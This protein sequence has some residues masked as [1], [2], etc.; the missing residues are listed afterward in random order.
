M[1]VHV[2]MRRPRPVDL[3]VRWGAPTRADELRAALADHLGLA[4]P[5][6]EVGG[7]PVPD[8]TPLGV[9]PLVDGV[10]VLVGT[11]GSAPREPTAAGALEVVVVAGPDAGR[12]RPLAPPGLDV[13]RAPG[14]GLAVDDPSLS[15]THAR[16][17]VGPD[18]VVLED[19]GSTNGVLVDGGP[20][21]GRRPVHTGSSIELGATRLAVRRA[22]GAGLPTRPV[23]DGTL[24][25]AAP[26][27]APPI[28]DAVVVEA[29]RA[30]V[31]E[32]RARIPWVAALVPLPV[33]LV[34]AAFL[35]P[36]V[37]AFAV[38]GPLAVLGGSLGDRLAGRRRRQRATVE[39]ARAVAE[40]QARLTA[41]CDAEVVDRAG[42]HPDPATVLATAEHRTAGLWAADDLVLRL[43]LGAVE[44]RT[45]WREGGVERREHLAGVPVTVDLGAVR[46]LGVVGPEA[47]VHGVLRWAAG[48]LVTRCSPHRLG[49]H[50]G[51]RW[52]RWVPHGRVADTAAPTRVVVV[53]PGET[54]GRATLHAPGPGAVALVGATARSDL[55]PEVETVLEV[56][57][58]GPARLHAA[59]VVVPLVADRVGPWWWE[60]LARSLAPLRPAPT[61]GSA[62]VPAACALEAAL[63]APRL[64]A[65]GIAEHW[66]GVAGRRTAR[67]VVGTD[68]TGPVHLDLT[69]DG[70][71]LLVAGTTG[72]GKSE[73]LRTLVTGLALEA[74]PEELALVL[75]DFKGGAAFGP[76]AGLPHVVGLVTDLDDHLVERALTSLTAEL[77]RRERALA[78]A[79]VADLDELPPA[80]GGA[81]GLGRLVIVVDE[82][83]ALVE[84]LPRFV[85]G[86]VRIAAQGRSLGIHLVLATQRPTGTVTADIQANVG[87]RVAFR[88][89]EAGDALDV[90]GDR[91]AA[92]IP[93]ELPGRGVVRRPDGSLLTFQAALVAPPE[94]ERPLEVLDLEPCV[95]RDPRDG[96]APPD[97]APAARTRAVEAV[98]DAVRAA[99]VTRHGPPPPAPWLPP[100]PSVLR[101]GDAVHGTSGLTGPSTLAV[102]DEPEA[103][104]YSSMPWAAD[105]PLRVVG[106]SRSGRTTALLGAARA[107]LEADAAPP[108]LHVVDGAGGLDHLS[109]LP[110]VGSVVRATDAAGVEALIAHLEATDHTRPTSGCGTLLLV[111]GWE[112]LVEADDG[113]QAVTASARLLRLARDGAVRG[114][115]VAVSGGRALLHSQW[116]SVG[117]E[118][119]LLGDL[120][121]L[122]AAVVGLAPGPARRSVPPGRALRGRDHR[123]VQI[124]DVRPADLADALRAAPDPDPAVARFRYVPLP[125]RVELT[126][127][128]GARAPSGAGEPAAAGGPSGTT[129]PGPAVLGI[130]G[131]DGSPVSWWPHGVGCLL[132][133][134]PPG[135]GRS[136]TLATIAHGLLETGA[137]V[138]LVA[139][140]PCPGLPPSVAHLAPDDLDGLVAAKR[141]HPGLAVLVDD[142]D[143]L[144]DAPTLPA[145]LEIAGLVARD[146]G[147][148][149]V[150]SSP[151]ALRTR[152]RG[153]DAV[154]ARQGA[155][156]L[157][158]PQPGDGDLLGIR[159]PPLGA[160]RV[161]G[162]GVLVVGA[163]V[164]A[165]QVA[166]PA[167]GPREA[168]AASSVAR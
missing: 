101:P 23:G 98:V 96:A 108:T 140:R 166:V 34:L 80:T 72:S 111:D 53:G 129:W 29:P 5:S 65:A 132:V 38:L 127:V 44:A 156:L 31:E 117:G 138:V 46:A 69:T 91:A 59:G 19:L 42:R 118:L 57:A 88:V 50:G 148:L 63:D 145:L 163:R 58:S 68:G 52:S 104:R 152:F 150:A 81:P 105:G 109:R 149:V 28:P 13:G 10:S 37:L 41:A 128:A 22:P 26:P 143:H 133:A 21:I 113:R 107:C 103:A 45:R 75:V 18:G 151:A 136:T 8:A 135:S 99:R 115:G 64:T 159:V 158:T 160:T 7:R 39:H 62:V 147:A 12:S 17:H 94:G 33:A 139:A 95:R 70:P 4:V 121:P 83:R 87:A 116:S 85:E 167:K 155:G 48:Q 76:C 90:V 112:T 100:L 16:L 9:P 110:H 137:P 79:G 66:S 154:V 61:A 106:R 78:A 47:A 123:E 125:E 122:D 146:G 71:H 86:L 165:V 157:L 14:N 49:L 51:A 144:D 32:P 141:A 73:F 6:L 27:P 24:D 30:P 124:L 82:L 36:Q 142:A 43:G 35:G 130:G 93:P 3:V 55:P 161:P 77:R 92:D 84:E 40:A 119:L 2:P 74:P 131:T 15:R 134:G 168:P 54:A 97:G 89:R 126:D 60:R 67:A 25:V 11:G 102:V 162:R 153:L 56:D 164:T 114:L 20:L 120:D 1:S